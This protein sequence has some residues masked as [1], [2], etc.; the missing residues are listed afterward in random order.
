[1]MASPMGSSCSTNTRLRVKKAIEKARR[2]ALRSDQRNAPASA[3][4][5]GTRKRKATG[6]PS[7]ARCG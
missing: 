1:M 4:A 5:I 7:V 2:G 3:N 6:I